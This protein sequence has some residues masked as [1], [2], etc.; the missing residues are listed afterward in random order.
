MELADSPPR[1]PP[2][3]HLPGELLIKILQHVP[4]AQRVQLSEVCRRWCCL[5]RAPSPLW[6]TLSV[7]GRAE[8]SA[9]AA[10]LWSLLRWLEPRAP[11][12]RTLHYLCFAEPLD[13]PD[14]LVGSWLVCLLGTL[15]RGLHMLVCAGSDREIALVCELAESLAPGLQRLVLNQGP[16]LPCGSL[17][18]ASLTALRSL[19]ISLCETNRYVAVADRYHFPACLTHLALNMAHV[20]G[21]RL[22]RG[23]GGALAA[24]TRLNSLNLQ[25]VLGLG[26][27]CGAL[28]ALEA[29]HFEACT[30]DH[31][32]SAGFAM[33]LSAL[34]SLAF[35]ASPLSQAD[36]SYL[37]R[38]PSLE[39]FTCDCVFRTTDLMVLPALPPSLTF[40]D[41][42]H[43]N[44]PAIAP[45]IAALPKLV[46]CRLA[47]NRM[48]ELPASFSRLT[49]LQ[50]LSVRLNSGLDLGGVL[51]LTALVELNATQCG[52]LALPEAHLIL[53]TLPRLRRVLLRGSRPLNAE[54]WDA[55]AELPI[56]L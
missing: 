18:L 29:A 34:R 54:S 52:T 48:T 38:L 20:N 44:V 39:A 7:S 9:R 6:E 22:C 43:F 40:L 17:A 55:W 56:E 46:E 47:E 15:G 24:L 8:S 1:D 53:D 30:F 26:A 14:H 51:G 25:G 16:T 33:A 37:P 12:V 41:L 13:N 36:L 4:R 5:L 32:W 28:S 27:G 45:A 3:C 23:L 19:S 49:A 11:A 50:T 42:A 21:D 10:A 31:G 2:V 35:T